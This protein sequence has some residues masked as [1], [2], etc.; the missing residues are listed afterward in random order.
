[1]SR[2][3][4]RRTTAGDKQAEQEG[5]QEG[6][7]DTFWILSVLPAPRFWAIKVEKPLPEVLDRHVGKGIDFNC[8]GKGGHDRDAE[9]VDQSLDHKDAKIHYRLLDAGKEGILKK[10]FLRAGDQNAGFSAGY[11]AGE[12][13]RMV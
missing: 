8:G 2:S 12:S 11:G 3:A 10:L 7:A 1:M 4:N 6:G 13:L 5:A 9:A